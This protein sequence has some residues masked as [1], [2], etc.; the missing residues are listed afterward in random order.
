MIYPVILCGGS[1][2]RLWPMSRRSYPKQFSKV[3]GDKTMFQDSILRFE[4]PGFAAPLVLANN[5]FRF[6][7]GEQMATLGVAPTALV[8]EATAKD[9]APA[10][11]AAAMYLEQIDPDA[12]L[13]IS[14]SDHSV[15]D[16]ARFR[17]VIARGVPAARAGKIVLFGVQPDRPETGYGYLELDVGGDAGLDAAT[18]AP[19]ALR[20]FIEKPVI[21]DAENY[22]VSG[23]HLWNSGVFLF[24]ARTIIAA[25]QCL[26][27]QIPPLVQRAVS[28][29]KRDLD[30]IRL[31]RENWDEVPAISIDYAI[32][33]PSQNLVVLPY[34]GKWSDMGSWQAI[35]REAPRDADDVATFG[36][37]TA[38]QCHDTVLRCDTPGQEL[39]GFGLDNICAVAMPDAVL[40]ADMSKSQDV[41][42]LVE[43]M[44]AKGAAQATE[45]PRDHRPW[46]W[47]ERVSLGQNFQVK[48]I[49]VK[50][51]AALSLQ[52]HQ[53]RAEHWVVVRGT[54]LVTVRD[55]VFRLGQNQS[56]Y[57][58][59]QARHRLENTSPENLHLI[60][61]QTGTYLGE[62][63][64]T[65]Y[66]DVYA[67]A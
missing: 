16:A 25:F 46:G 56:V 43:I 6:I 65:R 30:F 47:F 48:R 11:L 32:M 23:R 60:E 28:L 53:H 1:G 57:I 29:A 39:V 61:V 64:I 62:D 12:L 20:S 38:V 21:E 4:G 59:V 22:S 19:V 33:E 51:G 10:I 63:D 35:W 36:S 14:P 8:V 9:T 37:A 24:T 7:V 3:F 54:A 13:L 45:F 42:K 17:D 50:P 40:V 18:G 15:P 26:A 31:D 58:P 55:K 52:S 5:D 41:G 67:R 44:Q 2:T 49:M 34:D 66:E 27:P